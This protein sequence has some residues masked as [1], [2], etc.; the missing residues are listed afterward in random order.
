VLTA[1]WVMTLIENR[2]ARWRPQPVQDGHG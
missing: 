2:L 1:E